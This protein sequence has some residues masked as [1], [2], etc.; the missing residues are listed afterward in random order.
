MKQAFLNPQNVC[1]RAKNTASRW[2]FGTFPQ[3]PWVD[4]TA[5]WDADFRGGF[6]AFKEKR[7]DGRPWGGQGDGTGRPRTVEKGDEGT[8]RGRPGQRDQAHVLSW[9]SSLAER[10]VR[11]R[12]GPLLPC[13]EPSAPS[14]RPVAAHVSLNLNTSGPSCRL[15]AASLGLVELH[16]GLHP[17]SPPGDPG[18]PRPLVSSLNS[19]GPRRCGLQDFQKD[20]KAT[21]PG[22]RCPD[23]AAAQHLSWGAL[24]TPTANHTCLLHNLWPVP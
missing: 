17:R 21:A 19:R 8:G 4:R 13:P 12:Q 9:G 23:L 2:H 5:W 16:P 1:L 7:I 14:T 10:G 18:S 24:C 6:T 11:A 3:G 20:P 22:E 15:R